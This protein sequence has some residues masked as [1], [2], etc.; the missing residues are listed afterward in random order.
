MSQWAASFDAGVDALGRVLGRNRLGLHPVG[1]LARRTSLSKPRRTPIGRHGRRFRLFVGQFAGVIHRGIM[2]AV[3]RRGRAEGSTRPGDGKARAGCAM[4][5]PVNPSTSI[6]SCIGSSPRTANAPTY[7]VFLHR[8][9]AASGD[10]EAALAEAQA[11]KRAIL[12]SSLD[13]IHHD[14]PQRHHHRVQQGGRADVRAIHATRCLARSPRRCFFRRPPA[15]ASKTAST[16]ISTSAKV[17]S[18]GG[19]SR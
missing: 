3:A 19:A 7:L 9:A 11:R 10:L 17:R 1:H 14:R 12:E 15:P 8:K 13:P 6:R 4:P 2:G 16:G 18:W 5:R